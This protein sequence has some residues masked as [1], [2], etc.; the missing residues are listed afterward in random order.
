MF[1]TSKSEFKQWYILKIISKQILFMKVGLLELLWVLTSP[2]PRGTPNLVKI[3]ISR[4]LTFYVKQLNIWGVCSPHPPPRTPNL[5]KIIVSRTTS[6]VVSFNF[7]C[8][9]IQN[10]PFLAHILGEPFD[11]LQE[12]NM[13]PTP[14]R[15]PFSPTLRFLH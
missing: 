15:S 1:E 10:G 7:L 3:I 4:V 8:Q 2:S 12:N 14:H 9:A 5:V 11:G 6:Y 13:Q